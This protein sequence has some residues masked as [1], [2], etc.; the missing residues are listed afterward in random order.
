MTRLTLALAMGCSVLATSASA[1]LSVTFRDISPDQSNNSDPDGATGGRVNNVTIDPSNAS[2][3]VRGV[4]IR[5]RV[6]Q[7]RWRPD[8]GSISTATYRP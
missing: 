5:W 6:P 2:T 3:R 8:V 4:G 7:H 1:Q